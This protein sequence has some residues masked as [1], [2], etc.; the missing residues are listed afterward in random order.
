MTRIGDVW[1]STVAVLQGRAGLLVPLAGVAFFLPSIVQSG[2]KLYGGD[3]PGIAALGALVGLV[4]L[5]LSL[6]G[7]L[8][9]IAIASDPDT[10]RAEAQRVA[11]RRLPANLL[12][13][14]VLGAIALLLVVPIVAVLVATGYDFTAASASAGTGPM[15]AVAPGAALFLGLYGLALFILGLLVS[16]R[17]FLTNAV[18]LNE[19][20]GI[21]A[22]ARSVALTRGLTARLIGVAL[23]FGIVLLVVLLAAQSVVG[24]TFR[25]LLGPE[26]ITTARFLAAIAGAG[27]TAAFT[28]VVQV[29][30][31]RLY[32]AVLARA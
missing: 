18:V 13:L 27:V 32:A 12:V 23:L 25:L 24:L 6:W 28:T 22:V 31:A 20:R 2:V 10:T 9:V 17:L 5:L 11:L 7:Q 8:A 30:A 3:T 14:L 15:P 19:R 4:V 29:F 21:G 26:H 16:A 1:D